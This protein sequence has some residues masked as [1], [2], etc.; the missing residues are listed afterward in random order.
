[1]ED[2]PCGCSGR[3]GRFGYFVYPPA[4]LPGGSDLSCQHRFYPDQLENLVDDNNNP[5]RFTQYDEDLALQVV[6]RVL[7]AEMD[8][9]FE[10]ALTLDPALDIETFKHDMQIQRYHAKWHLRYRHEDPKI[11]QAIVN[12]WAENGMEGLRE[13]Q[14]TGEAESFVIVDLVSEALLPQTPLYRN[15]NTLVVAGTVVGFV[16][17]VILVDSQTRFGSRRDQEV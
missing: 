6:Q 1:V 3:V 2:R 9:A 15:R 17:G 5:V 7:L 11:A 10:Y 14:A 13:A 8:E 16:A 4:D 12:Y